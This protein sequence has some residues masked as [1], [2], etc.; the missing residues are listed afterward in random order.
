MRV[1]K[2]LG[3]SAILAGGLTVQAKPPESVKS[4]TDGKVPTLLAEEHFQ[5]EA[6][7]APKLLPFSITLPSKLA[8]PEAESG[9]RSALKGR[10]SEVIQVVC[11]LAK[12][13]IREAKGKAAFEMAEIHFAACDTFEAERWYRAVLEL[14]PLSKYASLATERL[15]AGSI[16][17]TESI[18]PPL[19]SPKT[20]ETA[21]QTRRS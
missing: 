13:S 12:A 9:V 21:L 8:P 18:E 11:Q 15:N 17:R 3:I 6:V 7:S 2:L 5:P 14:A 4:G 16:N 20:N 10:F 19:A 1:R